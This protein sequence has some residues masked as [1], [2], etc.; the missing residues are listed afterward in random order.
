MHK[1]IAGRRALTD[2][3][4]WVI[5]LPMFLVTLPTVCLLWFMAQAVKSEHLAARHRLIEVYKRQAVQAISRIEERWSELIGG[6]KSLTSS[7]PA[8]TFKSIVLQ[9]T[10]LNK[11]LP[12]IKGLLIL[13]PEGR[14]VYPIGALTDEPESGYGGQFHSAFRAEYVSCDMIEAARLYQ[15]IALSDT[16]SSVRAAA[17][18]GAVRCLCRAGRTEEVA[19]LIMKVLDYLDPIETDLTSIANLYVKLLE[20][21]AHTSMP[22]Y[23]QQ[24]ARFLSWALNYDLNIPSATRAFCQARAME[25]L[26]KAMAEGQ[27]A[28]HVLAAVDQ[29]RLS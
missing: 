3:Q 18:I 24:A 1:V 9:A 27:M 23:G 8:K 28:H 15:Q 13:G 17:A 12:E 22:E 21:M 11:R 2:P 10:G 6:I 26:P 25:L 29:G 19:D 14:V 16:G 5:W 4:R 7:T 20:I